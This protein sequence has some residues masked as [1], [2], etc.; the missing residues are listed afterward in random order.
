MKTLSLLTLAL[1]LTLVGCGRREA[2][3]RDD[4]L[5]ELKS[6]RAEL[7]TLAAAQTNHARIRW[8]TIDKS[9]ANGLISRW[10]HE[11]LAESLRQESLTAEAEA[12]IKNYET[13]NLELLRTRVSSHP[14]IPPPS[15]LFSSPSSP[16]KPP[17]S[18]PPQQSGLAAY[19]AL[20]QRVAE[21]RIPVADIL[22][23][24]ARLTIELQNRCNLEQ[25]LATYVG[26][27]FDL[28]ADLN[29]T[30]YRTQGEVPDITAGFLVFFSEWKRTNAWV[31]PQSTGATR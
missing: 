13:L 8:A 1:M 11:R 17:E 19:T 31:N 6:L 14:A 25:L 4:V 3:T 12:K 24:R 26:N 20:A 28:V 29:T 5:E 9:R 18:Q 2:Q 22:A 30:P 21:A 7:A 15:Q 16:A 23:R 27:R 10:V